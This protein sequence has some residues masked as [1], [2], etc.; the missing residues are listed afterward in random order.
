MATGQTQKEAEKYLRSDIA[1][2]YKDMYINGDANTRAM[3]LTYMQRSGL[4]GDYSDRQACA[5]WIERYW[6]K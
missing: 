5:D 1:S 4:Y 2:A 6:L 3:V